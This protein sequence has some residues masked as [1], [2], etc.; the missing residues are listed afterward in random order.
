MR[1][2]DL[3]RLNDT[4]GMHPALRPLGGLLEAGQ[5]AVVPGV[6]YPNPSR[7][8]FTGMAVW[9]TARLDPADHT[10]YG[11][12]GRALDPAGASSY[13]V[14]GSVPGALRGR[15]SRA[16]TML[17]TDEMRLASRRGSGERGRAGTGP[18]DSALAF[19]RRQALDGYATSDRL[20]ALAQGAEAGTL[21]IDGIGAA[22]ATR[23]PAVASE[24]GSACLLHRARGL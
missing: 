10:G 23:R 13:A 7:S 12:L 22:V 16:I 11:W 20:A 8:H 5:L 3:I 24:S 17:S 19:V 2:N 6:G 18:A 15:R 1:R 9:H 14:H 21:S 4:L